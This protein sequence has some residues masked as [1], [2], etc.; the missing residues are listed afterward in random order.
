MVD[1]DADEITVLQ[2]TFMH[3][4]N[5]GAIN[6]ENRSSMTSSNS[7]NILRDGCGY[8][9]NFPTIHRLLNWTFNCNFKNGRAMRSITWKKKIIIK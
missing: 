9:Y 8:D 5:N 6:L 4:I 3:I 7:L 1:L 2:K